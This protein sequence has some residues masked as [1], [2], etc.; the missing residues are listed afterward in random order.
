MMLDIITCQPTWPA[1]VYCR[2][3]RLFM[4]NF[5]LTA[6]KGAHLGLAAKLTLLLLGASMLPRAAADT[7]KVGVLTTLTGI[8]AEA[9]VYTRNAVALAETEIRSDPQR[10]YQLEFLFED[11]QYN[12][13][14]AVSGFHKLR[15]AEGIKFVIGAVNSSEVLA[16]AP[17]AERSKTLLIVTGAQSD[18]ISKA[19]DYVFRLIH[20]SAQEA[21]FFARFVQTKLSTGKMDFLMIETAATVSYL[22]NFLP[23]L[24]RLGKQ[25]GVVEQF[26]AQAVDFRP[27][28]LKLKAA[29]AADIFLLATPKQAGLILKQSAELGLK[30][31]FYSI[32]AEGPD[33]VSTAGALAEGLLY[34]YS[35]DPQ[36]KDSAVRKFYRNYLAA[37]GSEPDAIAA[38]GYDAA[39]LISGCFEEVGIDSQRVKDCLYRVRNYHGASGV[40]YIDQNGDAIKELMIKTIHNGRFVRY[41]DE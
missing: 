41:R 29:H 28:L 9:G 25:K 31:K 36:D 38:N 18:E 4:V 3:K 23:E 32:G 8:R 39:L 21:P 2:R 13:R 24:Q 11:T 35:Y 26:E 22:N 34:A 27:Q 6:F 37:Y 19:G 40:F 20:N 5:F 15:T 16:V 7:V 12:P 10:R 33:I 1:A 14:D 17:L 30:A